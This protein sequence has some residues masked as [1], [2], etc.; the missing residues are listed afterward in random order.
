[1]ERL[2][3]LTSLRYSSIACFA[4]VKHSQLSFLIPCLS[5]SVTFPLG[6]LQPAVVLM[7][8][9]LRRTMDG[10]TATRLIKAQYPGVAILG[11]SW[12]TREYVVSAMQQAGALEVLPKEQQ[13]LTDD[14]YGAI[15]RAIAADQ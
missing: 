4:S 8:I 11:L 5:I 13:T 9:H 6:Q 7:D 2:Y 10:I 14:W 3:A 12:D 1:M 15:Q